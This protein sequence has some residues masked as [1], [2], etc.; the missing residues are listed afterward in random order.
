LRASGA[1]AIA[2]ARTY[3]PSP[4]TSGGGMGRG[5]GEREFSRKQD[6][7]PNLPRKY[8][9]SGK[10]GVAPDMRSPC[11]RSAGAVEYARLLCFFEG[12]D[13]FLELANLNAQIRKVAQGG[14]LAEGLAM[15]KRWDPADD[16]F[17]RY[18]VGD[19]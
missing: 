18:V 19:T 5:P 3:S 10:R 7:P 13:L 4:G 1:R 6:P 9:G 14:L 8:R 16:C 12:V 17:G 11:N 15:R 2:F